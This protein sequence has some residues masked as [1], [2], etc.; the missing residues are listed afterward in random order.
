MKPDAPRRSAVLKQWS[1]TRTTSV[2]SE[3]AD[4]ERTKHVSETTSVVIELQSVT[5]LFG[6]NTYLDFSPPL[7]PNTML[8]AAI[9]IFSSSTMTSTGNVISP[10]A[11]LL[12]GEGQGGC[13]KLK[14]TLKNQS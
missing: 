11:P 14:Y 12:G 7:P 9:I 10:K 13:S 1:Q 3:Q 4:R 6:Q 5:K 8:I 2:A